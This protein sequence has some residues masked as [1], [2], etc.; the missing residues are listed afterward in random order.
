[1]EC[2]AKARTSLIARGARF[3]KVTLWHYSYHK[4]R[5]ISLPPECHLFCS[6]KKIFD[7]KNLQIFCGHKG[8]LHQTNSSFFGRAGSCSSERER[9][10]SFPSPWC[11]TKEMDVFIIIP[12]ELVPHVASIPQRRAERIKKKRKRAC[13]SPHS[14]SRSPST[15]CRCRYTKGC[16]RFNVLS[17]AG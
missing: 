13:S 17:C 1:M 16:F 2:S 5:E 3:L 15:P 7:V 11:F 4:K 9:D 12:L 8:G 10:L 6:K 14:G